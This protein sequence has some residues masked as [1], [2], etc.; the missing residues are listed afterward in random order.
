MS[1][2][3]V[4]M[5]CCDKLDLVTS[6]DYEEDAPEQDHNNSNLLEIGNFMGGANRFKYEDQ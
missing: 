6:L 4:D 1:V 2:K 5:A 3:F